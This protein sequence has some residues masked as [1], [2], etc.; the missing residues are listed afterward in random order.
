[1]VYFEMLRQACELLQQWK[2]AGPELTLNVNVLRFTLSE[3]DYLIKVDKIIGETGTD[4]TR[5]VF[6]VTESF[7]KINPD[8]LSDVLNGLIAQGITIAIDD[9]GVEA[10]N[11]NILGLSQFSIV[12]LD[13]SMIDQ[14]E[15]SGRKTT[16]LRTDTMGRSTR[17]G[18]LRWNSSARCWRG[19]FRRMR[20]TR[21]ILM[22][23]RIPCFIAYAAWCAVVGQAM[24]Q[25]LNW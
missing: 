18:K 4:P 15:H 7:V 16:T 21:A 23:Q 19:A 6:E 12:K 14:A 20:R 5:L 3:P 13:K 9:F 10:S 11:L 25:N 2:T 1:M 22:R 17:M 8:S 24:V